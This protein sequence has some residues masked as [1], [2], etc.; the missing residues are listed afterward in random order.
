RHEHD[1]LGNRT[2]TQL[3]AVGSGRS[4]QT[5]RAVLRRSLNYLHYGSGH[6]HQINLGLAEEVLEGG[7]AHSGLPSSSDSADG[8]QDASLA[9]VLPE[10]V[11]EVHRLIA[12][13]ERDAL[14]R[15]V[16]R[17]QGTLSTRYALDAL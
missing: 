14:H 2:R 11:R 13:I 10:P 16:L 1:A 15:E 8:M 4:G 7:T 9:G 12:D 17:T 6:L 3:P 5:G